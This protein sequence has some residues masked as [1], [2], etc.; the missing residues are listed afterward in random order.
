MRFQC[1]NYY[2]LNE[3]SVVAVFKYL[4]VLF[5]P[6]NI[7]NRSTYISNAKMNS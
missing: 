6:N 1:I 7:T 2:L 4:Q 5:I 3:G